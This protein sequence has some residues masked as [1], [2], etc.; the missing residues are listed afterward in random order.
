MDDRVKPHEEA[1]L[2]VFVTGHEGYIGPVFAQ[3]IV[4]EHPGWELIGIDT[5]FF[6]SALA[7][8]DPSPLFA[9]THREDVRDMPH[10]ILKGCNAVVHLAALSNDPMGDEFE[11]VTYEINAEATVRIA[12][13]CRDVGARRFI[14]ASSCSMYGAGDDRPRTETEQLNPLTAYARAKVAAEERLEELATDNFQITC[15]RFATACGT[16]PRLRL[17]LVI[18][19][20]VASALQT[21]RI[22]VLSDG[23]PWRPL[24]HTEDMA[25]AIA[26]SLQR[27]GAPFLS[28]NIGSAKWT[29][30]IEG[31]AHDIARILGNVEVSI[32]TE[33]APDNRSYK[34]DFSLF[35]RMAPEHQPRKDFEEAVNELMLQI[36][37]LDF[38]AKSFRQTS[39]IRLNA[40]RDLKNRGLLSSSLR[41]V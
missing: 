40:L 15:L 23:T 38:H 12:R 28:I 14:F 31:L 34:V 20:F 2:K 16:S 21:G 41:W 8:P 32:N 36:K 13:M 11:N 5:G 18:N 27:D 35:R 17:D 39:F 7:G 22:E 25:R 30:Q 4:K 33:A 9:T 10:T 37:T 19:D 3:H 29:W 6:Q 26:W 1:I 24:I